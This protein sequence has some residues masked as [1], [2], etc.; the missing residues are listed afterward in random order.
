MA[1]TKAS[2]RMNEL[3]RS[4]QQ[5]M[6]RLQGGQL[7]L[8]ELE[9][10]TGQAQA[11]YERFVV[12]RHKAREAAVGAVKKAET[13]KP[14]AEE[15]KPTVEEPSIRL[16]T[17][18]PDISPQQTSL[19][20]AIAETESLNAMAAEAKPTPAKPAQAPKPKAAKP[21]AKQEASERPVTV[22]DKL[23]HAP[24]ADLRKAIALSQ[25]FWFVA[26][27]F[28][29]DRKRYE[30]AI[31]TLNTMPGLAEADAYLKNEVIAKLPKPPGEEVA[32]TFN[33][34]LQRRYS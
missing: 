10:A 31:D 13:P 17:R 27:L 21:A 33:E 12:L 28:A 25:K 7:T 16:D 2:D 22:A 14:M 19:I 5:A 24:V 8:E 4:L 20:D 3:I 9:Q 6:D 29:N 11:L 30:E 32:A 23:E 18:P 15:P 34:L 1:E 26:E